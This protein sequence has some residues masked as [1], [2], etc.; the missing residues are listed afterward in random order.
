MYNKYIKYKNKY[1]A[2]LKQIGGITTYNYSDFRTPS[3]SEVI[4]RGDLKEQM[5]S[6]GLGS[7]IYGF[8]DK[9]NCG[10][11]CHHKF[12]AEQEMKN[13]LVVKKVQNDDGEERTELNNFT[14]LSTSLN[15]IAYYIYNNKI[16][17]INN[18]IEKTLTDKLVLHKNKILG[19]DE[20]NIISLQNIITSVLSFLNDYKLLMA[21]K[22]EEE[23]YIVMPINYLLYHVYDGIC[24]YNDDS[25]KTGSVFY[26][27]PYRNARSYVASKKSHIL[28]G[29]LI[30][31]GE[32][33][34]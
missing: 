25:G 28:I 34:M 3:T 24:N 15:E 9:K 14:W 33:H 26:N 8:L 2:L 22:P 18:Y 31:N 29:R 32:Y 21:T 1:L 19:I 5:T 7:G 16:S 12:I 30:F 23:H 10:S 13:C 17:N 27:F 4:T 11:Y 6:H 20:L